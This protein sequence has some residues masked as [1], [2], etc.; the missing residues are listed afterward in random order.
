MYNIFFHVCRE[1][2]KNMYKNTEIFVLKEEKE[3]KQ[4]GTL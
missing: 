3:D 2:C 1:R 4:D